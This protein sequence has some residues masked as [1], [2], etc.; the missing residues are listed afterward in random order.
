MQRLHAFSEIPADAERLRRETLAESL[1]RGRLAEEA[2]RLDPSAGDIDALARLALPDAADVEAARQ[3][4]DALIEEEKRASAE[5]KALRAR[6]ATI[7]DDIAALSRAG[8]ALTRE[9]LGAARANR[10]EAH[11]RLAAALDGEPSPRREAFAALGDAEREVNAVADLLLSD[12]E[13]CARI[14]AAREHKAAEQRA[15]EK[16]AAARD[17]LAA[18][19]RA[20]QAEWATL[21]ERA[22]IAPG[23]PRAMTTW[24]ERVGDLS[25]RRARLAEQALERDALAQKLDGQRAALTR[26]IEDIGAAADAALPI[27][28]LYKHAR[29]SVDLLQAGWTEARAGA[30][31]RDK[32]FDAL[33]RARESRARVAQESERVLAAWPMR[34]RRLDLAGARTKA[35][36][37]P[38]RR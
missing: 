15:F 30:A 35:R 27:E 8:A 18:R 14:E 26:L 10:D 31:L 12:A 29:A 24:L 20:A 33:A 11:S 32:A 25:R 16:L 34:S 2:E 28:A 9:D 38:R 23:A 17:E 19:R 36:R 37:R 5:A 7:D 13:R 22:E 21:W 1:E 3:T 6:L 4:F